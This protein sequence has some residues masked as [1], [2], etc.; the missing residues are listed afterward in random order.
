VLT[1]AFAAVASQA[2]TATGTG[3][4]TLLER[5][6]DLRNPWVLASTL[7]PGVKGLFGYAL[8][9]LDGDLLV[10]VPNFTGPTGELDESLQFSLAPLE[11]TAAFVG[12]SFRSGFG[13]SVAVTDE[14]ALIGAPQTNSGGQNA[15]AAFLFE[16]VGTGWSEPLVLT[17]PSPYTDARFGWSVAL[18]NDRAVVSAPGESVEDPSMGALYVYD[19]SR[20]TATSADPAMRAPPAL[21][22]W[23]NPASQSVSFAVSAGLSARVEIHVFSSIGRR[24]W[25]GDIEL[26]GASLPVDLDVSHLPAGLYLVRARLDSGAAATRLL[27]IAR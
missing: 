4:I 27:T 21:T 1:D 14:W 5:R 8:A 12:G 25:S 9:A 19:L 20:S 3:R 26:S 18:E 2:R 10:G 15:G 13:S 24:I 16:R 23:P 22:V 11:Q 17:A 6:D 7:D